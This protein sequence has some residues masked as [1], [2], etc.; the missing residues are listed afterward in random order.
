[1]DPVARAVFSSWRV[2]P[3]AIAA[4]GALA[5]VYLR[6]W[7]R[8][9]VRAGR[10]APLRPACFLAALVLLWV[11]IASPLDGYAELW[12]RAHMLQHLILMSVV[13]PLLWLAEP[14]RPLLVGLP[15]RLRKDLLGPVLASPRVRR[16]AAFLTRPG[17]AAIA[18]ALVTWTWHWPP[19]YELALRDP[20]WHRVEHALFFGAAALLW[21]AVVLPAPADRRGRSAAIPALLFTVAQTGLL[22]AI[23]VFSDRVLYPSYAASPQVGGLS[24]LEDQATAGALLWTVDGLITV[25]AAMLVTVAWLTPPLVRPAT[26]LAP[27]AA[28]PR[29]EGRAVRR[30]EPFD[31][32]AVPIAGALLSRR[33]FRRG[34]RL[35]LLGLAALVVWDGFAG[36]PEAY[37]NAAGVLP[38]T[39]WRGLAVLTL[40]VGGNFFC[41][42]CPFVLPRDLGRKLFRAEHRWPRR[43]RSKWLAAALLVAWLCAYEALAP[44]DA[45]AFTAWLV[46]GYFAAAL[47]IDGWFRGAAFCKYVCPIGQFHFVQSLASPL[48]VRARDL[49]VCARCTTHDCF[50]GRGAQRGCEL[51]LFVPTKVGSL[52]CTFCLDCAD[53]C[54]RANVG[55]L[56]VAPGKALVDPGPRSSIGRWGQRSDVAVLALVLVFG[57]FASAAAMTGPGAGVLA[58]LARVAGTTVASASALALLGAVVL[59]P[60]ASVGGAA[61]LGRRLAR[62]P[63]PLGE[64]FC[65]LALALVPLGAAMWAAHLLLHF[66]SGWTGAIPVAARFL[67]ELGWSAGSPDWSLAHAGELGASFRALELWLLDAGLLLALY[68]GWRVATSV[69]AE[70]G[71]PLLLW[72]PWAAVALALWAAGAWIVFQPMEMRGTMTMPGM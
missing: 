65:R 40:L 37:A 8:L 57:A 69:A 13:P 22:A 52:D 53:A 41:M 6:G 35:A 68:V 48:E 55:I 38:W 36:P 49:D 19:L 70:A 31:L 15:V 20:L 43:L 11:A 12:L 34:L 23:L 32:L 10:D 28:S 58:A 18:L 72:S 26:P 3:W 46:V 64:V 2:D 21:Y 17:V 42:A 7:S 60:L 1:M 44:W 54:P 50:R 61:W 47:A 51:E 59:A 9:R 66:A 56:A 71:R 16:G 14:Y 63:Q 5:W 27:A 29:R 67:G 24:A 30:R 25:G 33:G 45:P 39:H 62:A 4:L